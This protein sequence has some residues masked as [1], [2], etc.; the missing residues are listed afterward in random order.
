[1]PFTFHLYYFLNGLLYYL[2][3]WF[4]IVHCK[5]TTC[6]IS[7]FALCPIVIAKNVIGTFNLI[8]TL[9]C[10]E[11]VNVYTIVLPAVDLDECTIDI[12]KCPAQSTCA[13]TVGSFLCNCHTGYIQVASICEG[14]WL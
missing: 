14:R 13:N 10:T 7:I 2:V 5:R 12:I 6:Q 3:K 8:L 4:I 11:T 9:C 1:M